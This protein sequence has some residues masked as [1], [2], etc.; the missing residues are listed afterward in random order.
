MGQ[1]DRQTLKQHWQMTNRY[2]LIAH[3]LAEH[4]VTGMD[5]VTWYNF[6]NSHSRA[7]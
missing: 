2:E 5:H 7:D 3:E 6:K 4:E 1:S